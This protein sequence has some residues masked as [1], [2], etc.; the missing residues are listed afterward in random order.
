[1]KRSSFIRKRKYKKQEL[2]LAIKE[3]LRIIFGAVIIF[4]A[5]KFIVNQT[6]YFSQIFGFPQ[7]IISLLLISLGTNVPELSLAFRS[8]SMKNNK[9]AFGGYIGSAV[10]NTLL[11]GVLTIIYGKDIILDR[12]YMIS[13]AFFMLALFLF[14]RFSRSNN[15]ISRKEGL[16]LIFLYVILVVAEITIPL[17]F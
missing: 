4:V 13:L 1:M 8:I 14:Y 2:I 17:I 10:I 11:F 9:V 3:L 6:E 5:S 16:V 15:S 7:F 12:E